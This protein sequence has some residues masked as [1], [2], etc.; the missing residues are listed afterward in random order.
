MSTRTKGLLLGVLVPAAVLCG[1]IGG[2]PARA[3][4]A[5]LA[6]FTIA[7]CRDAV[8]NPAKVAA[9]AREGSW[10]AETNTG[11]L[12]GK[13]DQAWSLEQDGEKVLVM[14]M[15]KGAMRFCGVMFRDASVS[16]ED[17]LQAMSG[18]LKDFQSMGK[19]SMPEGTMDAYMLMR[20]NRPPLMFELMALGNQ[21]MMAAFMSGKGG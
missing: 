11:Q 10:T 9:L 20:G 16:R 21:G 4:S 5:S 14:V 15:S 1:L 12:P 13:F 6:A 7:T 2:A 8:D 18:A 3:D 17:F 19:V